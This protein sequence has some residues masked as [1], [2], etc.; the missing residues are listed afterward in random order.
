[1]RCT[2][3]RARLF[4]ASPQSALSTEVAWSG[5]INRPTRRDL[6]TSPGRHKRSSIALTFHELAPR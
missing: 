6:S 1:M 3:P 2:L 4:P 5:S